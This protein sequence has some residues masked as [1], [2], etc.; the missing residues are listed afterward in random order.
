MKTNTREILLGVTGGI[1]SYKAL[2]LVR[3]F[4]DQ[5]DQVSVVMTQSAC[6]FVQPLSFQ[7][8]SQRK[9]RTSLFD[10]EQES[11]ISHTVL[12]LRQERQTSQ[13]SQCSEDSQARQAS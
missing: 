7:S 3:K 4:K 1:A 12:A 6:E 2:E 5:G 9:V 13:G 10:L 11:Q 8:L